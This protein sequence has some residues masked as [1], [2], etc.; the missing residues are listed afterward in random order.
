MRRV[1]SL[2][3]KALVALAVLGT[4]AVHAVEVRFERVADGV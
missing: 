2:L 3:P 4:A 1:V